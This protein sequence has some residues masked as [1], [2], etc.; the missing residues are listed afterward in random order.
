MEIIYFI[1]LIHNSFAACQVIWKLLIK[2]EK[3]FSMF[4]NNCFLIKGN[5]IEIYNRFLCYNIV[6]YLVSF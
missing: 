3:N 1:L 6:S 2:N 4:L 5:E